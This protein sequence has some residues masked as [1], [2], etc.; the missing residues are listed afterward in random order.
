MEF[1]DDL[2][3]RAKDI[4]DAGLK[5]AD[6]IY[7]ISK[8]KLKCVQLDNQIK[9]KYTEL[10]KTVYGMVKHDSADSTK[11]S[12]AVM[13]I[14]ALYAKMRKVYSEIETAKKKEKEHAHQHGH[15][16]SYGGRRRAQAPHSLTYHS[17]LKVENICDRKQP[18]K[19]TA[20]I[21]SDLL[22]RLSL[23]D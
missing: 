18:V 11:I 3:N 9:A 19:Q 16:L 14:E 2:K 23:S 8:L 17:A 13:E 4:A 5:K 22:Y 10:G 1:K 12:E 7:R 6:E 21:L 15:P 20:F